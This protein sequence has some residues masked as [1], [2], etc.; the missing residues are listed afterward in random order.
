MKQLKP[1]DLEHL[2]LVSGGGHDPCLDPKTD[3]DLLRCEQEGKEEEE[4]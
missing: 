1:L 3:R 2:A 4:R